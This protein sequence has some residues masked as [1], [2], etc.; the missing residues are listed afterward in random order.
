MDSVKAR[1]M[2]GILSV[3]NYTGVDR[4][5]QQVGGELGVILT[6]HHVRPDIGQQFDPNAH[7]SVTPEFL[8]QV[9]KLLKDRGFEFLGMDQV[10]SRV[11]EPDRNKRFAVL[12]FDDGYRDTLKHAVPILR[13][14]DVPYTVYIAPGLIEK[15]ADL[16]WEGLELLIRRQTS[17]SVQTK[18]GTEEFKCAT[19][20]EKEDTFSKLVE[21]ITTK[22]PEFE[23][24]SF[25][26]DLCGRYKVDLD[27]H[28]E[29]Q[30]MN[31]REVKEI[32]DD[33]LGT[34]GAHTLNH[35]ALARITEEQARNEVLKWF[36]FHGKT[37]WNAPNSLCV[38][39]WLSRSRRAARL[40]IAKKTRISDCR[41]HQSPV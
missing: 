3:L 35:Q 5:Y 39:L 22:I 18:T 13:K 37:T 38:S 11:L 29:S 25:I 23:H 27:R 6:F 33:P 32:M 4:F 36:K 34:L 8:K 21:I 7:L 15:N 1:Y 30:L 16:W 40:S 14:F 12:T 41:Y 10:K 31:W 19:P 17:I 26:R 24:R 28:L 20:S 2:R 9:L